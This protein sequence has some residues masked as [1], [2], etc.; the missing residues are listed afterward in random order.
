MIV[1]VVALCVVCVIILGSNFNLARA[2][3][4]FLNPQMQLVQAPSAH[5]FG[6][7]LSA[8]IIDRPVNF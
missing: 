1:V 4:L 8:W 7:R 6:L 3:K 2:T 5:I